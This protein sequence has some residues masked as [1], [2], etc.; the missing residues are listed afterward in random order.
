MWLGSD[1]MKTNSDALVGNTIVVLDSVLYK[2][3]RG[4]CLELHGS[5]D[6]GDTLRH[7]NRLVSILLP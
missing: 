7:Y 4:N 5:M 2:L 1:T 3:S 6:K